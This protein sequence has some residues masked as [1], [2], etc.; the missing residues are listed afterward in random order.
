MTDVSLFNLT[1]CPLTTFFFFPVPQVN[2]SLPCYQDFPYRFS[3]E[4]GGYA[5]VRTR[6]HQ[7]GGECIT[8]KTDVMS[9]SCFILCVFELSFRVAGFGPWHLLWAGG[10][11][12]FGPVFWGTSG[13]ETRLFLPGRNGPREHEGVRWVPRTF[14]F[15]LFLFFFGVFA[16][17][18]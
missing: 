11:R 16:P 17:R 2:I 8:H 9:F 15:A 7:A 3:N 12:L 1:C 5:P 10:R 14:H 6:Q 4:N 18:I 13:C